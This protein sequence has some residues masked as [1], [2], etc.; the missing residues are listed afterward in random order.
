MQIIIGN[1]IRVKEPAK[2]L[3]HWCKDN[4]VLRNPEYDKRARRGCGWGTRRNTYG[5]TG[6]MGVT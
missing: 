3:Q 2:P 6:W 1:E 4:L 5:S